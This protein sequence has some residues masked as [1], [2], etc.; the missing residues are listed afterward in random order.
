M[1]EYYAARAN[2][3]DRVYLKP[4][5][6]SDLREIER[7][8]PE[9]LAGRSVL[10]VAC[11][12]G[13][14]TRH[15]APV[16]TRVVAVDAS[17]ETLR[18]AQSRVPSDSVQF[19]V[20]DAYALPIVPGGF[21]GGFAGFWWSHVPRSRMGQFLRGFNAGLTPGA[22][23]VLIDNRFVPGS[24][25]P[26]S[27]TDAE[28]NTYQIRALADGSTHRILKNFPSRDALLASIEGQ[29]EA[30]RYREWQYFWALEYTV[31]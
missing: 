29:A 7:W 18:V 16:C 8:L 27:D 5:R 4:E 12:T 9:A 22:K 1:H 21:D 19:L 25:T 10:E 28:G 31:C 3:Y 6:Q 15:L 23:V 20:G 17:P 24:S 30:M 13:Y 11:G 2:E 26:I 14:W